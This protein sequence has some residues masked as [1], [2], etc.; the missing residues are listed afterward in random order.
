MTNYLDF[1]NNGNNNS[2][3]EFQNNTTNHL[4]SDSFERF[5][6]NNPLCFEEFLQYREIV[7]KVEQMSDDAL[8]L[9]LMWTMHF[10][11][12]RNRIKKYSQSL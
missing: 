11:D 12:R 2:S 9:I 7:K 5:I 6:K 8:F 10:I 3:R 4:F 1:E